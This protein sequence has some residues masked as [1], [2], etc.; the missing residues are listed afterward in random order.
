M[1]NKYKQLI[2]IT[3]EIIEIEPWEYISDEKIFAIKDPSS[4]E[5]YYCSI[6]GNSEI[7]YG[8]NFFVGQKGY[9]SI[10]SLFGELPAFDLAGKMELLSLNFSE[11]KY[12]SPEELK[13]IEENDY[14]YQEPLGYCQFRSKKAGCNFE[15]PSEE[16]IDILTVL[17]T[18]VI[19]MTKEFK[20][21]P[22]ELFRDDGKYYIRQM[23][24]QEWE[25]GLFEPE[26]TF[27]KL[28]VNELFNYSFRK[29]YT[30][31]HLSWEVGFLYFDELIEDEEG[32]L[33]FPAMLLIADQETELII[34][35][36]VIDTR[37]KN[38]LDAIKDL[39]ERT[40]RESGFIPK[41]ILVDHLFIYEG[42]MDYCESLGIE[43]EYNPMPPTV[44]EIKINLIEGG[45]VQEE[46]VEEFLHNID[47][48]IDGIINQMLEDGIITENDI[49]EEFIENIMQEFLKN[50]MNDLS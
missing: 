1:N 46:E 34:N 3:N 47:Q 19:E 40:V 8:V 33:F 15:M 31:K 36:H 39:F 30:K 29:K 42:I 45:P 32:N 16:E 27:E 23:I 26:L 25:T 18:Q 4:E 5:V 28:Q 44:T 49:T 10:L 43:V 48:E 35:E 41:T 9:F 2:N 37:E 24:D 22:E 14:K 12:L 6:L 38:I 13:I 21:T 20:D 50:M 11:E 17:L 7:E